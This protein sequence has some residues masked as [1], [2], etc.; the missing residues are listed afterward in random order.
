MN[1]GERPIGAGAPVYIIAEIGV[2]HDGCVERALELVEAAG[3]AGAD[4]IKVQY[5][6]ADC[7]MS[8]AAKL[9]AYQRDA[10]EDDPLA[11]L[12]RLELRIE[13]MAQVVE[14]AHERGLHAI[15]T[16]FSV[17]HIGAIAELPWDAFKTASPDIV[18]R[19]LLTAIARVGRPMIVSTGA[20]TLDE[21]LSATAWL[22]SARD[23]LALLQCVSCYPAP[24]PALDGVACLH[25][26]TTL[27]VGYSDHTSSVETGRDAVRAGAVILEK[28]F[29]YDTSAPGPDH[30]A[31]LDPAGFARYVRLARGATPPARPT[32]GASAA[33]RV[34][35]C[36]RDVR[37]VS[38]QSV[39][40]RRAIAT[41]KV[42]TAADLTFKRPGVGVEP[43]R[44]DEIV[45]TRAAR[46]IGADMPIVW[47][48]VAHG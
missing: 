6:E 20:S 13:E 35:D 25:H 34:L 42:I 1:I 48:D 12:R 29:T 41:G 27:P 10:G 36:E 2:N 24:E 9:A 4:A 33:K 40:A 3:D 46:P 31:S 44:A 8:H 39:V 14:R 19:P 11:M 45:G 28:H 32:T 15:V 30:R 5:F 21:V 37:A 47:D 18:H 26:A 43:S 22:D 17:E 38:R 23:R 7:L 16:P